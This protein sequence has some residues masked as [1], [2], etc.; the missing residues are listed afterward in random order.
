MAIKRLGHATLPRRSFVL[1]LERGERLGDCLPLCLGQVRESRVE[2]F[3]V[4][5]ARLDVQEE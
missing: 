3:A 5:T 1:G 4:G 2:A